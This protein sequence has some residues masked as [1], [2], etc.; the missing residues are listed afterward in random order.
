MDTAI[1]RTD[2]PASTVT[3]SAASAGSVAPAASAMSPAAL[4]M[5]IRLA[6][7]SLPVGGFSHSEGLEAAV[8]TGLVD[9]EASACGW[10]L[11]QLHLGLA[12]GDMAVVARAVPAWRR[13]DRERIVALNDWVRMT[14]ETAEFRLQ[15]EQTGRSL[16]RWLRNG[17]ADERRLALLESLAPAPT[18]PIAFALAGA[19]STA[20]VAEV[21]LAFA[22]GWAE[23]QM[24]AA[25]R[26]VPLGQ[27]A[28]QRI[29]AALSA[30]I[31]AAVD[32]ALALH[33]D[34]MQSFTPMLAVC[35]AR[36]ETQYS[37]LFRS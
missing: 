31:P 11:D 14:R 18:W 20:S 6:S 36:H 19:V 9:D 25:V 1:T 29:L 35:S 10:L 23:N 8:D 3:P 30:A 24:Q 21:L 33:D 26:A 7:P 22:A 32:S 4:L 37:R 13:L 34:D 27:S 12:R 2:P 5:L 17:D 15:T 28:G 16:A